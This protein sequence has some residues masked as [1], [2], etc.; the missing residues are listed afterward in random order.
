MFKY[1]PE[2]LMMF[3]KNLFQQLPVGRMVVDMVSMPASVAGCGQ[4]SV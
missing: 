4:C 1:A 2:I 3:D